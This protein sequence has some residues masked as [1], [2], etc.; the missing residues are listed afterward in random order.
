MG[1]KGKDV[2]NLS[3]NLGTQLSVLGLG[4][5]GACASSQ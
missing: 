3:E 1:A 5:G 4:E 2:L